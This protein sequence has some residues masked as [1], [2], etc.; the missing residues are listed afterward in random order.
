MSRSCQSVTFS[1][2]GTTDIRTSRARPVRFSVRTGLRLCGIALDPFW[3]GEKNSSA[4]STSVRCMWRISV[5]TFSIEDAITPSVAKNI[6]C[7]SR[8]ITCVLI[9]SGA[10]PIFAQ[11]CAST[12]GSMLAKVPTAPDN[13]PVATSARAAISRSR[14]RAIS[15]WN[16]AKV[17]P[18]V[19]GSAWM[20]WLRPIRTSSLCS[21]ARALSAASTRSIPSS[22]RS[23][24]RV[25]CTLNV[26]SS[27]SDEVIP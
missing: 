6:A 5:A 8:G 23:A 19:V 16:R 9:G 27:T 1:S 7:R 14:P 20:P 2:A 10:R 25:S 24:A 15:A 22:S 3:P 18:I 26:V 12:A 4:S 13:A 17:S 11:T 21:Y